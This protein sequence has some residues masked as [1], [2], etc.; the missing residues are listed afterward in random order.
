MKLDKICL[1]SM[2]LVAGSLQ[3]ALLTVN[4]DNT[5]TE[6]VGTVGN[7]IS[8]TNGLFT[9]VAS[10]WSNPGIGS[11]FQ[12]AALGI[13]GSAGLGV[14]NQ[15]ELSLPSGCNATG[16]PTPHQIDNA[17]GYDFVKF[18]FTGAGSIPYSVTNVTVSIGTL[19]GD[20]DVSFWLGDT[21]TANFPDGL[22][23]AQVSTALGAQTDILSGSIP[24]PFNVGLGVSRVGNTLLFG[25]QNGGDLNDGFKIKS[26][27]FETTVNGVPEPSTYALIGAGLLGL[28]YW[29]RKQA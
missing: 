16:N 22:T 10:A 11:T 20:W 7:S 2:V 12:Q 15:S 1:A 25:P 21:N 24:S 8:R 13:Y 29:R 6:A 14:C 26:V 3:G 23:F 27:S 19:A 5:G 4:F 9:V 28:G 17:G 18:Q